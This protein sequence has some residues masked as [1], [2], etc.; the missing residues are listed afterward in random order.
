M[1]KEIENESGADNIGIVVIF[2]ADG[3]VKNPAIYH[4]ESGE[5]T[6]VGYLDNDF[7][8]SSGQYVIINTY[9]CLLYTSRCV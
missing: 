1:V 9:T 4:T 6:K 8:M 3:A 2:R 5:F 7:I